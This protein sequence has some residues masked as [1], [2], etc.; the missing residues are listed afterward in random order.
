MSPR[1]ASP[2]QGFPGPNT[3]A[4]LS[5]S[6]TCPRTGCGKQLSSRLQPQSQGPPDKFCDFCGKSKE[7]KS[8]LRQGGCLIFFSARVFLQ[9][10]DRAW[11][12]MRALGAALKT[13][14]IFHA[15]K[16]EQAGSFS[17][18]WG[19]SNILKLLTVPF[20]RKSATVENWT[21]F[22]LQK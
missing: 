3:L 21:I 2:P 11:E 1:F 4:D 13:H 6:P 10:G 14:Q 17:T 12:P 9:A 19:F 20:K 7:V 22:F 15:D 5:H 18:S 8:L 16:V